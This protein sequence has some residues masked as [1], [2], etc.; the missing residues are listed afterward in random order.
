MLEENKQFTIR[1]AE[2]KML[3]SWMIFQTFT[4]SDYKYALS[5]IVFHCSEQKPLAIVIDKRI[6]QPTVRLESN[7][8]N[9]HV[10]PNYHEAGIQYLGHITGNVKGYKLLPISEEFNFKNV[11]FENLEEAMNWIESDK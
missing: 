9:K 10:L 6:F 7:W 1:M 4:E 11:E 2:D 3:F 8:Y 5:R